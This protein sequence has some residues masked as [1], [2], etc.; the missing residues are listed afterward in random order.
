LVLLWY[1]FGEWGKGGKNGGKKRGKMEE[2]NARG[3]GGN[4]K[5][6]CL[7]LKKISRVNLSK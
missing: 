3:R 7:I 1:R 5:K 4:L 2:R 6:L